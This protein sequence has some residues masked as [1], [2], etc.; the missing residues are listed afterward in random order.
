[1]KRLKNIPDNSN[2]LVL[3]PWELVVTIAVVLVLTLLLPY[4]WQKIRGVEEIPRGFRLAE[5]LRDDYYGYRL[6]VR[7][8]YL[9]TETSAESAPSIFFIGDSVVWG[10]YVDNE[11]TLPALINRKLG[12]DEIV[13][14]AVDGL[15]P[16]AMERL[17]RDHGDSIRG[18]RVFLYWNPLWMNAPLYDLSGT[19]EFSINHPRLLPQFDPSFKSYRAGFG[20]RVSAFLEQNVLFCAWL[21]HIRAAYCANGDVKKV[22]ANGG[23]SHYDPAERRALAN[24]TVTWEQNG[25]K[26][27]DW[28]WVKASESRQYA[29]FRRV[30]AGLRRRGNQVTVV[31][32]TVNPH[33][34]TPGSL[35]RYH[36]LR[37]EVK[38]DLERSGVRVIDLPE[39][40]SNEYADA[41]HP[42][43]AG[44]EKLARYMIEQ[45][46]AKEK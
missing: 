40:E 38:A 7:A 14:L 42:L 2:G 30:I 10:K 9:K 43:A 28:P 39:L 33:M 31:L 3:K 35:E 46:T 25:I 1:M 21:R 17:L 11:N 34:Q 5:E 27:Q 22:L 13:N 41:S 6:V 8:L 18:Y 16:V 45:L 12:K 20:D 29:A 26:K 23:L 44:Y 32:G 4:S 24:S 15:H 19:D 37:T 36:K